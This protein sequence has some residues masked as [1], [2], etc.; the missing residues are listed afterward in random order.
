MRKW[1]YGLLILLAVAGAAFWWLMLDA[2]APASAEYEFD[3]QTYRTLTASDPG[4]RPVAVHMLTVGSDMAPSFAT[5]AGKF[6]DETKM[7]YTAFQ[8]VYPEKTI[9]IGGAV[10]AMTSKDMAQGD[11]ATFDAAAYETLTGSMLEADQVWLTHEH[12]DHVMA[13]AR[14]PRPAQLAP[15]L[16]L[17]ADQLAAMPQFAVA[18]D[19]APELAGIE[20]AEVRAP[21]LIAPGLVVDRTPGHTKGSQ[22]FLITTQAGEEYLLIGD[23]VWVMSN[24]DTLKTRPRLLQYIVFEPN[25]DRRAVLRQV[26]ALHDLREAHPDVIILP[27]HDGVYLDGLVSAGKLIE[28]FVRVQPEPSVPAIEQDPS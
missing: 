19:L 13:I 24:L 3:L 20:P 5:E 1:L 12:I 18:G 2:R 8:I 26:R 23:I 21:Y 28:G 11:A 22:T 14:H 25:E 16:K 4:A 6:D 27:S 17:N 15:R 9:I 7:V 10:D